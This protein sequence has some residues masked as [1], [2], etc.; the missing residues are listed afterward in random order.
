MQVCSYEDFI[1]LI[2]KKV[3]IDLSSYKEKQM[4]RRI[5]SLMNRNQ[6]FS[7]LDYYK[8]IESSQKHMDEFLNYLTINVSEFFRNP[9]Q[10]QVLEKKILPELI[11]LNKRIKVWSC[12][13]STGEEAYSIT[14]ILANLTDSFKVLATDIDET[15][16]NK[17]RKGIYEKKIAEKIPSL[18]LKKYFSQ[19]EENFFEVNKEIKKFIDFK[20]LD[21]LKDPYPKNCDLII[22]RNVM[23]Y[24]TN[25]AKNKVY[26][27]IYDSLNNGGVLFVGSTE[28]ILT[29]QKFGF[30]PIQHFFYKKT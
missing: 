20:K 22:C 5:N 26:K 17:A 2:Q 10:W 3:G 8:L 29:P 14:M 13:C 19:I 23:I 24:F 1:R 28:Q 27:K 9:L 4:K 25:E 21:I 18:M 7:Y 30:L 15:V 11:K 6:K 12:A 16:L